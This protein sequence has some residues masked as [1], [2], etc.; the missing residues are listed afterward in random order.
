MRLT[1][2]SVYVQQP[3]AKSCDIFDLT[4]AKTLQSTEIGWFVI[5]V[6]GGLNLTCDR[7]KGRGMTERNGEPSPA[8]E[9]KPDQE[10]GQPA[11]APGQDGAPAAGQ[12]LSLIHISE[13]TR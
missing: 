7:N 2:S 8:T 10:P 13:P 5:P 4:V 3:A 12:D 9:D 11:Q 6:A 1:D